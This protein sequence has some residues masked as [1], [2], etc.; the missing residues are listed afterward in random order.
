MANVNIG[1]LAASTMDLYHK[2]FKDN[3][4]KKRALMSHLQQNGGVKKYSSWRNLRVPLMYRSINSVQRF[5]GAETLDLSYQDT[6][7]AAEYNFKMYNAPIIFTKE[8]ELKNEGEAQVLSLIQA[9]IM[10]A[11][12][13]LRE[14]INTDLF[15]GTAADNDILGLDTIIST[16]TTLGGIS[17]SSYSWWQGNV[18]STSET[19]SISDMR[20]IKN[21]CNNGNGGS[22]VSI[23]VTTQTLYEKYNSLLTATYQMNPIV[24]E[25][26]R[27]GDAGFAAVEFEGV[28]IVY[29]ESATSGSMYF[30][31][32]DNFKL[33][34][35]R[36][37]DFSREKKAEPAD[38]HVYVEHVLFAGQTIVDRRKSLG[39]LSNKTS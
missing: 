10:Q 21:S 20:T 31:N 6:L 38:Q 39:L 3:I 27:L 12:N 25:T 9:K 16:T 4:F 32:K 13:S 35:H 23:I 14:A 28:P 15:S 26:R 1:E 19:L 37:A 36:S 24:K 34:V 33:G 30:I 5:S 2:S 8:D 18:D 17:G 7:D 22:N 29:D 11:E